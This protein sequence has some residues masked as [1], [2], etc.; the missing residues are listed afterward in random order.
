[1]AATLPALAPFNC[2]PQLAGLAVEAVTIRYARALT[3]VD[4]VSLDQQDAAA[5]RWCREH[6]VTLAMRMREE[7]ASART[8]N[9][10]TLRRALTYIRERAGTADAIDADGWMHT[11]DLAVMADECVRRF[12]QSRLDHAPDETIAQRP[13]LLRR[14]ACERAD[15]KRG[16][17]QD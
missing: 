1:M 10:T 6:F 11:G 14:A 8:S 9:R 15:E 16:A 5:E 17:G 3:A 4:G 2:T 12:G 13:P 7:G